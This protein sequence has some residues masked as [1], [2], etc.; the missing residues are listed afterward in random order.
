MY[1]IVG[2]AQFAPRAPIERFRTADE[3]QRLRDRGQT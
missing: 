2:D 1:A 3:A